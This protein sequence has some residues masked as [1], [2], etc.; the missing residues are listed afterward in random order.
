M[1]NLF[2]CTLLAGM[3]SLAAC[4]KENAQQQDGNTTNPIGKVA[5][6][7]FNFST[8]KNVNLNLTLKANN[9]EVLP[10]VVVSVYLPGGAS[11]A[12]F[13]GVTDKNGQLK[14][15]L[16]VPASVNQLII[17]PA[18]V[19]LMRNAQANVSSANNITATIGGKDGFSGDII[20][21]EVSD[22][23]ASNA[24]TLSTNKRTLEVG[25]SPALA[26]PSPYASSAEAIVNTNA[27]PFKLGRPV[28]LE[29]TPDAI[30]AS[31]L[32]YINA[33]LPEGNALT[34]THPE[35]LS[36]TAMPDLNV[37]ATSDVWITFVSEGAGLLNSLGYYT[38]PTNN[39]PA[40]TSDI[41]KITVIFPNSSA[42]GSAGGL[43]S[44]DKVKLGRFN[45]GTSIGFVLLQ[46]AWSTTR[47][48]ITT[49]VKFYSNPKF[50]PETTTATQKHTVTLYDDVHKLFLMG[51]EDL[52]RQ[53]ESDNDFND[54]VVYATSNPVTAISTDG[55]PSIDKGGDSDGDGVQDKLDAFPN[56]PTRAYVSYYP[57]QNGYASIAFEDN[58][59]TKGDFDLNDLVVNYRYTFT[60]NAQNQVVDMKGD[61]TP[62]ASGASFRNGFAIQL[63]IAAAAVSSVTGQQTISNYINFAG[64]GVEAGQTKAVIVPFDNHE[65]LLKNGDGSYFI[66][67]YPDKDKVTAK[68][69]TVMVTFASPIAASSLQV[70]AFNPFLISN[71]RRGYEIHLPG[72]APTDKADASLFGTGDDNSNPSG[73]KY[74]LSKE[75]YPWAINFA[76]TY[77][78]PIELKP[79][80]QA[81]PHFGEW[82]LSG[83]TSFTDW[84]SN[85][86]TGYRD[87]SKIYSK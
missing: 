34:K 12:F 30:D 38:Y 48:V 81:Y 41:S 3:V 86:T 35:Y 22:V 59:P 40:S 23:A 65:A 58:W 79:V 56:D 33:S 85:T 27:Y 68:T 36:S 7:G 62:V 14:G 9:N 42:V 77:N 64:N 52:N 19:G 39:P 51:F 2:T 80:T 43:N 29:S 67:V 53:T 76:G 4:K 17:D 72:F 63:P 31:L 69:A 10:G 46:N 74:Y 20:A 57:S 61:F 24:N 44:G 37:K 50:N 73:S 60:S 13:K 6:D 18:Y 11:A 8:T 1:K 87:A 49:T 84:Y 28:Y 83:G 54:L 45:A 75:N 26:Y 55:V 25:A 47:G 32:S 70:S 78:Y 5:P 71:M 15:T 82:A 16:T 21:Q 66:N